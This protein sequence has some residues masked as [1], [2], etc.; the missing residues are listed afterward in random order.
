MMKNFLFGLIL[1]LCM[2]SASLSTTSALSLSTD[3]NVNVTVILDTPS[4]YFSEPEKVYETIQ[5]SLNNI[6]QNSSRYKIMP[7]SESDSYLQIYREEHDL[8]GASENGYGAVANRDLSLKKEN[9]NEICKHF[10]SDYLIY[11]RVTNSMPRISVGFMSAGQKVNVIL[12]FR[13]WSDKKGDYVYTKRITSTG[14]SNTFY[15]GG[16]GSASHAVEKGLKK[17]LKE[18]EKDASKIRLSM[19]E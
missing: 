16:I 1:A 7:M 3:A 14:S 12:D 17:G 15:T 8:A 11:T 13:V 2:F 6:F 10:G 4:G 9:V 19:I 18:V 5:E